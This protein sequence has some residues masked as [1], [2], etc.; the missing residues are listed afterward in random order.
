MT[1]DEISSL[2][3]EMLGIE[4]PTVTVADTPQLHWSPDNDQTD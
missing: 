1:N 2:I 3:E 4:D